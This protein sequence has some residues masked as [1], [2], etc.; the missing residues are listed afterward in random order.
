MIWNESRECMS[1]DELMTMQSARLKKLVSRVYHNVEYYR[2]KMQQ[3]GLEPG[4]I[5]GIEDISRLPYTTKDDLR[6]TYPFGLFAV[7]MSEI[8]RI[9]ASSGTT[10]KA[11]VVGYTRKDIDTWSECVARCISMA[12]LGRS[13]LIQVAYGYGLFTGGLGAHYGAEHLGATVVPM[14]TGNTQK[15]ITMMVDFGVT[16][17]MCTPSYLMHIAETIQE[18]GLRDKIKLKASLNGAEPWT[19]NMRKQIES[20]LGIK[21]HDIY[22]LSEIM[23][24][25]VATDCDCHKGLHVFEDHFLPEIIDP[26]TLEPVAEDITGELV[27]TTLT[28]EGIPLIRYRTKD[29]T[30]ISYQQCD[31]G[32]TSARISRFKGR[33]DDMLIIRGVNVFPSQVEAALLSVSDTTPNYQI[34]VDRVNNMDTFEVRVEVDEKFFSDKIRE[35]ESLSKKIEHTIQQAIG[36]KA[37]IKLVEPKTIER[38]M[39]KAKRVID[40]RKLV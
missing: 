40:K 6:D 39:G 27:F 33:S 5:R 18:E 19:D 23:G 17:I 9:H 15:L 36:L 25:G 2:K 26:D 31:C 13:D 37:R 14:S 20:M 28:K 10:G 30:S 22:G 11:T 3:V 21:C 34:I 32:R 35:L 29:L 7:P 24:P 1:R 16:G 12:G 8:V 4:D 38:S